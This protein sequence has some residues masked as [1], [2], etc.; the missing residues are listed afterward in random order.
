MS[1]RTGFLDAIEPALT[2]LG[3][4]LVRGPRASVGTIQEPVAIAK[5]E[6]YQR[7]PQAP[8]RNVTWN[9][10]LTIASPLSDPEAAEQ[11]LEDIFDALR[12][13]L[14]RSTFIYDTATLAAWNDKN[15]C[16]DIT[17]MSIMETE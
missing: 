16:L 17:I 7:T 4:R 6:N 1:A 9:G 11:Q 12:P 10:T 8:L 14:L 15:L 3:V 13:S 5:T 2:A